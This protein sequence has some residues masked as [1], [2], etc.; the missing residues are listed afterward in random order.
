MK[1]LTAITIHK[2]AFIQFTDIMDKTCR[3][4]D[5]RF[6]DDFIIMCTYMKKIGKKV[7]KQ[8]NKSIKQERR[9]IRSIKEL[10]KLF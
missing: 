6:I 5:R 10:E 1:K 4:T 7:K 9:M 8:S 3:E 2:D